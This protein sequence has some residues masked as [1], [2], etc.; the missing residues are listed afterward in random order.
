MSQVAADHGTVRE[1]HRLA[2]VAHERGVR[3]FHD[4]DGRWFCTSATDAQ[5]VHYVTALSC[6]CR[7]FIQHQR[8]SHLALLLKTIG[9]LPTVETATRP[10][11]ECSGG[12]V[13]YVRDCARAGWPHPTCPACQGVGELPMPR[14]RVAA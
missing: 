1:L 14:A 13:I 11:P 12:G 5:L 10:C 8:C 2:E 3:L 6:D 7:G 9:W 4:A